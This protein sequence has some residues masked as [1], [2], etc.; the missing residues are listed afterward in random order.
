MTWGFEVGRTYRRRTNIHGRFGG[1][2]Q[3]GII[4]PSAHPV[5]IT[6]IVE[7]S[8]AGKSLLLFRKSADGLRFEGEM[9]CEGYHTEVAPDRNGIGR[10][11]IVFELRPLEA[12]ADKVEVE[13]DENAGSNLGAPA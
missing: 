6:A 8:A 7:H 1:Q 5:V 2:Q 12:I 4:T 3:G 10:K 9:V 13:D 11:A